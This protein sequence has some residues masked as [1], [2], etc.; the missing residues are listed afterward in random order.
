MMNSLLTKT[1]YDKRWF[2]LGWGLA[3]GFVAFLTIAF[4]PSI[5]QGNTLDELT[6][7]LPTQ[8]Q[9]IKGLV[10]DPESFKSV[11]GYMA[12]QV[13]EIRIPLMMLIAA[14]I[15]SQN[16]TVAEEEKGT[17]RTL[18]ATKL[19]RG[20]IIFEK[21]LA[22]VIITGLISLILVIAAYAGLLSINE[23]INYHQLIWSLGFMT[24]LCG[25]AA[26]SIVFALGFAT[27]NRAATFAVSMLFV[28]GSFVLTTFASAVSWLEPYDKLSLLHYYQASDIVKN[29]LSL[30][31]IAVL[32]TIAIGGLL[33]AI[34]LFRKRDVA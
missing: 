22:S 34:V 24:W 5:S 8:L 31:N 16:I 32:S 13:F 15:L 23:G 28:I 18:L 30:S 27:G 14:V 1:L 33:V 12:T 26:A 20:R 21:W 2:I 6:K 10:G 7:S 19:S 3:L 29:G 9:A 4:F 17:L 11:S 25:I